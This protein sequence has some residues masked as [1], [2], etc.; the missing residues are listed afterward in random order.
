MNH[1]LAVRGTMKEQEVVC[2]K[3]RKGLREENLNVLFHHT[4]PQVVYETMIS[5]ARRRHVVAALPSTPNLKPLQISDEEPHPGLE[6]WPRLLIPT[7]DSPEAHQVPTVMEISNESYS[8]T[9]HVLPFMVPDPADTIAATSPDKRQRNKFVLQPRRRA[10]DLSFLD[11]GAETV[12]TTSKRPRPSSFM[13]LD[14]EVKQRTS[15]TMKRRNTLGEED[16]EFRRSSSTCSSPA[17]FAE[18]NERRS[19]SPFDTSSSKAKDDDT[20]HHHTESNNGTGIIALPL[21]FRP[22]IRRETASQAAAGAK[23]SSTVH[24]AFESSRS[25]AF[26]SGC[27]RIPPLLLASTS[28]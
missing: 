22:T 5:P 4:A 24:S 25:S 12:P 2:P 19:E 3:T 14:C 15:A 21:V 6:K 20:S 17:H 16:D 28:Y 10:R 18:S 23:R 11:H 26:S 1:H 13:S 27:R 9:P 7:L 8:F